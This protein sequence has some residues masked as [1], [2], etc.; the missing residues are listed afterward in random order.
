MKKRLLCLGLATVMVLS[1]MTG[2]GKKEASSGGDGK[3]LTVGVP[4]FA[5]VT[6]FED[7][8]FTTYVEEKLGINLEFM[9]LPSGTADA[10]QKITLMAT[11]PNEELPDVIWGCWT[12]IEFWNELGEDDYLMDLTDLLKEHGKYYWEQ[13]NKLPED[14]QK[15]LNEN[16]TNPNNGQVYSL[17]LYV[18]VDMI[19]NMQ[20]WTHINKTWLDKL[21]LQVPTTVAE[22]ENVLNAF[23]TKDPNGNGENDEIGM[24][25]R[26]NHDWPG[27]TPI[28]NAYIYFDKLNYYNAENGKVYTPFTTDEYRQALIKCN[29]MV[30]KGLLSDLSYTLT[31]SSEVK[32]LITP[33]DGVAKVGVWNGCV[34]VYADVNSP[35]LDEYIALP[36]LADET[37]K[38]GYTVL[39][40]KGLYYGN[41]IT[42]DCDDPVTAI[43]F[44]D[45]LY[46][47]EAVIMN[48]RGQEGVDWEYS[49]GVNDYGQPSKVLVHNDNAQFEGNHTWGK[50]ASSIQTADNYLTIA[51]ESNALSRLAGETYKIMMAG[52]QPAEV[53]GELVYTAKEEATR[54]GSYSDP[55]NKWRSE[56]IVGSKNP[57]SDSDWN[58][59]LDELNGNGHDARLKAA[60]AAYDRKTK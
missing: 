60:Q 32:S 4:Q 10:K 1:M 29:E 17:P 16:G 3:T 38:G 12:G 53:V 28:I 51:K 52:K 11:A 43:K 39:R 40:P 50:N 55:I 47:D 15:R 25:G 5:H 6:S 35:V 9:Y 41:V 14:E 2:C 49:E 27:E 26:A 7:N 42:T 31:S 34:G 33:A 48:R 46:S 21:G 56:F 58:A 37:G 45:F 57:R 20:E 8:T 54:T 24:L 22:L 18:A 13:F 36:P 59:Y 30:Q 19:D 44:L 23:V